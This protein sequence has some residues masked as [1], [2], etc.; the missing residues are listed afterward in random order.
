MKPWIFLFLLLFSFNAFGAGSDIISIKNNVPHQEYVLTKQE[1]FWIYT[2]R[3]RFWEDGSRIVVFYMDFDNRIHRIFVTNVL[4]STPTRFANA[5]NTYINV[6]N[7]TYFRQ[8]KNEYDMAMRVAT[9][10]GSV[11]YISQDTLLINEGK[12]NVKVIR[13]VN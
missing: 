12:D 13:I 8:V 9:T 6:G 7:A 1:V 10:P 5:V 3:T 4:N 2:L 11:G